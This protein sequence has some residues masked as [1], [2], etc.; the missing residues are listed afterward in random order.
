MLLRATQSIFWRQNT[1]VVND[2][3]LLLNLDFDQNLNDQ[4]N[5]YYKLWNVSYPKFYKMDLISKV[6]ILSLFQLN[7]DLSKYDP[8]SIGMIFDNLS[9]SE[10]A[11]EAFEESTRSFA[12]PAL[13]VY[14]LPNI[15]MGEIAIKYKIKGPHLCIQLLKKNSSLLKERVLQA[16]NSKQIKAILWGEIRVNNQIIDLSIH[17]T[18]KNDT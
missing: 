1:I 11:D 8:Y 6:A 12:S 9:G 3:S 16:L 15:F 4:L 10:S 5:D 18:T 2:K 13:F 14:T 17:F 7:L